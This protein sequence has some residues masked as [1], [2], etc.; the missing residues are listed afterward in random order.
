MVSDETIQD[1]DQEI[2][3][4]IVQR[5]Q[6]KYQGRDGLGVHKGYRDECDD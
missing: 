1:Q 6:E 5:W 2:T 4:W 3:E